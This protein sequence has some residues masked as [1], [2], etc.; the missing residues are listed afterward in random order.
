[1]ASVEN[2]LNIIE[3]EVERLAQQM[4]KLRNNGDWLDTVA[5]SFRDEPD[6]GEILRLGKEL[7]DQETLDDSPSG[8]EI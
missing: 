6:F 8:T 1:M 3:S 7:R 5:G 4:A 2:R